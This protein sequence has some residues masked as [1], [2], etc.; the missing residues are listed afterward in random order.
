MS[1]YNVGTFK[2]V[3]FFKYICCILLFVTQPIKAEDV[4]D[5]IGNEKIDGFNEPDDKE[6]NLEDVITAKNN[7]A[8]IIVLNKITAKSEKILLKLGQ[9]LYVG[10]LYIRL[11]S[12]FSKLD[13]SG[14]RNDSAFLSIS[15][16]NIDDDPVLLFENWLFSSNIALNNF[17]HAAYQVILS[18][19]LQ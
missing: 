1:K 19:C 3:L 9:P 7:A 4:F 10:N 13:D 18:R 8:E 6:K 5:L 15:E 14:Q 11:D 2:K 16:E 17:D 12:C